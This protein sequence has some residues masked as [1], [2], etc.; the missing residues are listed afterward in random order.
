[1]TL[2]YPDL[3]ALILRIGFGSYM[4]LGHG[5]AKMKMLMAGGDIQFPSVVGLPPSFS[6]GLAVFAEFIACILII[7]G[8]KTRLAAL[9]MIITMLVAAFLIHSGDPFFMQNANGGASKEP[10]LIY[11]IGFV[12]IYLLGSGK[13]SVDD[14]LDSV[15]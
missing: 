11:F 8:Y 3:T 4:L 13:Y 5:M 12:S 14:K 7:V 9:P 6:L 10:A 2:I 1:M 15:I